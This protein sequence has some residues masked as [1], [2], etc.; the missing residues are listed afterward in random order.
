MNKIYETV[1]LVFR[2]LELSDVDGFFEMNDNPNVNK[3][4]RNPVTTK[5][6]AE[7]Y[8]QKIIDEYNK[9]GISRFA[10]FLKE[11]NKLIGFSGLK[12]RNQEENNHINFYDLGY[13]FSE[14]YW[15][16]GYATEAAVFWLNY[17]FNEMN[18]SEIYASAV[19]ENIASNNLLKK[20]GFKMTNQYYVN[21][22]LHSW[23]KI[24]K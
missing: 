2:P 17:G 3:F 19:S 21:D 6:E 7:K 15:K 24:E 9:N 14:E 12:Y 23:N 20:L 11:N 16:K 8:I 5:I 18:L 22:L 13:R 1:R 10:V 4:L